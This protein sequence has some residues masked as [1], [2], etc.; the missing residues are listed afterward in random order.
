MKVYTICC[1]VYDYAN[2]SSNTEVKTVVDSEAAAKEYC[3]KQNLCHK[4]TDK[5]LDI[6]TNYFYKQF[7]LNRVKETN[8]YK[9]T[10]EEYDLYEGKDITITYSCCN[11]KD[12]IDEVLL[13]PFGYLEVILY[14]DEKVIHY[15]DI[16]NLKNIMKELI[17][18]RENGESLEGLNK[19]LKSIKNSLT[20]LL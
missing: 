6:T 10:I 3:D 20:Y 9:I 18:R 15:I 13:D 1:E 19:Y 8:K 11:D 17:K 5:L 12:S 7:T 2:G 4:D 14:V 16:D